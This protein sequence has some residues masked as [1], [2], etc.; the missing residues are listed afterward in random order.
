MSPFIETPGESPATIDA[1]SVGE[2][3]QQQPQPTGAHAADAAD[4]AADAADVEA[5]EPGEGARVAPEASRTRSGR[6]YSAQPAARFAALAEQVPADP[7]SYREAV[8]GTDG[9]K[10]RA[11][12]DREIAELQGRG[13]WSLIPR[14]EVDVGAK[15]LGCTWVF[16]TKF[17]EQGE[18][19][20]H[21]ARLVVRGD[22][23]RPGIDFDDVYAPTADIKSLRSVVALA[24]HHGWQLHICD[25]MNAFVQADIDKPTFVRQ[26][27]GY[28]QRGADGEPLVMQLHK[29]LYGLHQSPALW[30]RKLIDF[31][32]EHGFV[33]SPADACVLR[34]C[35]NGVIVVIYVDD[36]F[37]TG[38]TDSGVLQATVDL[39]ASEFAIKDLG[40]PTRF[41]GIN[42][43]R[44]DDGSITLS[45]PDYIN[46]LLERHHQLGAHPAHTPAATTAIA[47]EESAQLEGAQVAEYQ[48]MVGG[49]QWIATC[50]RPDISFTVSQL[51]RHMAQPKRCH[52][53]AAK[54]VLHYLMG[55]PTGITYR[56]QEGAQ[57]QLVGYADA[58]FASDSSTRRSQTGYTFLL[59]GAAV[60]WRSKLQ[61]CVTLSSTEAE[62]VAL[63][64]ASKEVRPL[65]QLLEFLGAEQGVVRIMEDN[66]AA[67]HLA[68]DAGASQ[69][70][71]HIDVKYHYVREQVQNGLVSVES[72]RTQEQHADVLTKVLGA[73]Q[74]HFHTAALLGSA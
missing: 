25:V 70:T 37:T 7:K 33:Q 52:M 69:R 9:G 14:S 51:Q 58:S 71:K 39:I 20:H 15:V 10:W 73:V 16:K 65:A 56:R 63:C 13:T 2:G 67:I 34:N 17:G 45:Q 27:E 11:A 68:A 4:A 22:Q 46:T 41:L 24:A 53:E 5:A 23:Q 60:V 35:S 21:K 50:T 18:V 54:R 44:Q 74:H 6:G 36:V 59:C 26:P 55:H 3:E 28:V 38:S 1:P 31:L 62:Y 48:S 64:E 32:L 8:S 72:V 57:L 19:V 47:A 40:F 12:C 30:H 43:T 66:A 61:P 29:G 49:L 42:F